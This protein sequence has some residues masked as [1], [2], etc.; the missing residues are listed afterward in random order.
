[1][2]TVILAAG[3]GSRL[4]PLSTPERPKQL[5][6]LEGGR[7]LIQYTYELYRRCTPAADLYVLTLIDLVPQVQAQLSGLPQSHIIPVPARRN[8]LPH[9]LLALNWLGVDEKEPVLFA[10]C[11]FRVADEDIFGA[12]LTTFTTRH[13][14]AQ[15]TTDITL[16]CDNQELGP[17][18]GYVL[19][20]DRGQVEGYVDA[21]EQ[22]HPYARTARRWH[23]FPHIYVL[24]KA[25]LRRA[26]DSMPDKALAK[27]AKGLLAATGKAQLNR[28]HT[29]MPFV[30]TIFAF[31]GN[32]EHYTCAP[33]T[34]AQVVPLGMVDIGTF[35]ALYD[36]AAKDRHQNA[37][38]GDF[39]LDNSTGNLCINRTTKP[40]LVAHITDSIIVQTNEGT[41]VCPMAYSD[42][43]GNLYKK[44]SSR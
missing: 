10:A 34:W 20:D 2:K 5:L 36:M 24:S 23:R 32:T 11:D 6:P 25:A 29:A 13:I 40:T 8:V 26:L 1:M 30:G 27:Q 42:E 12:S 44:L 38:I 31:R 39:M 19:L 18:K 37:V 14:G 16:L 41:V 15:P 21:L 28:R 3:F 35:R 7:S 4:W 43:I 17:H 9:T 22:A 33:N